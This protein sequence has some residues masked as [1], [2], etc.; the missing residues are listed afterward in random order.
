MLHAR[1]VLTVKGVFQ[2]GGRTSEEGVLKP[3]VLLG[4]WGRV[5]HTLSCSSS[6]CLDVE[7]L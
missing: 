2:V 5:K 7:R 4:V 1:G 3:G 6:L